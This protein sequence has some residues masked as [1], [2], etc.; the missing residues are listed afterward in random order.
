MKSAGV[1]TNSVINS[2]PGIFYLFDK[3][4]KFLLWNKNFEAVS[5][6]SA[7]ELALMK[8]TD[9]FEGKDKE[10]IPQKIQTVFTEGSSTAEGYFV[11][12]QKKKI[13]YHFTGQLTLVDDK[14]CLLGMGMDISERKKF[15]TA[16][17][18]SEESYKELFNHSPLP[19][20]I[21]D[22][23]TFKFLKVSEAAVKH[24]GYTEDEF[25]KLS[26]LDILVKDDQRL[27][28]T[29]KSSFP[30]TKNS[31]YSKW[32][33]R[34]KSGHVIQTEVTS[35]GIDYQNRG[36]V[37]CI[38]NDITEKMKMQEELT[39]SVIKAQERERAQLGQELHDNVNQI[40]TTVKLYNE[41]YGSG[42][43]NDG[44]LIN[45][46]MHYLQVC[47]NEIRSISKR[48]SAP[49]LGK[50]SIEDSLTELI[51]SI[52]LTNRVHIDYSITGIRSATINPDLHLAIYRIVQ[53]QL[54]NILKHADAKHVKIQ[55]FADATKKNVELRIEDDGKGF[56]PKTK[57]TGIG[58]ANIKS[59]TE[60]MKGKV[61]IESAPGRGF[62]LIAKFPIVH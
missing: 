33:H 6:F 38:V 35:V 28:L 12:K 59:R 58:L 37:L 56:N 27:I 2:L 55:L 22:A 49:T 42:L 48:L 60:D 14:P 9:F 26:I 30:I 4:G 18:Q 16:L 54:N 61:L 11:T 24:Y 44:D 5:G 50:I 21:L 36:A 31:F 62:K 53:E 20:W 52:N 10:V 3:N 40:L 32:R 13:P 8:P 43:H 46:S 15:E 41:M 29:D 17:K 23:E 34:K 1:N 45:K 47:I 39:S 57:I 7:N 19:Q 51:E 25:L